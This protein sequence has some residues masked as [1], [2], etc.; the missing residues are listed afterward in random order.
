MALSS[1]IRNTIVLCSGALI[2]TGSEAS[3]TQ[4]A[5]CHLDGFHCLVLDS[6]MFQK[7]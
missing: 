7:R 1:D 6:M 5:G 3:D 2:E 4:L